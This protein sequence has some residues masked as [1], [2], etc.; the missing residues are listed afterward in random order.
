MFINN[1]FR[2]QVK[3]SDEFIFYILLNIVVVGI[4]D[5]TVSGRAR[6]TIYIRHLGVIQAGSFGQRSS[7]LLSACRRV[8]LK[9]YHSL[10]LLQLMIIYKFLYI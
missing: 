9:R 1:K 5:Y 3:Y 8:N 10:E 4:N 2:E 7:Q 6:T